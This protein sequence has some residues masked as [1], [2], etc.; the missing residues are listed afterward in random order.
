MAAKEAARIE[1]AGEERE[2]LE[3]WGRSL[4]APYRRV[5]RARTI[6]LQAAGETMSAVARQVG[7][8]RKH[9]RKWAQRF[10]QKRLR[11]LDDAPRSGRPPV[12][13]PRGRDSP[14]QDRLRT[15]G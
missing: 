14:G 11:G 7:R 9:V 4:V 5:V 6:L 2:E 15:T 12:F 10:V 1:L 8:Q 13:S 3:R